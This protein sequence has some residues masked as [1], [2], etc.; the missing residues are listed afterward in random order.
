MKATTPRS[1]CLVFLLSANLFR[2][3]AWGQE[4]LVR[5]RIVVV[6]GDGTANTAGQRVS[7]DPVVEVQDENR[8]AVAGAAVTFFLPIQG[9]TGTFLN[10]SQT[11]TVNTNAQGRATASGI[12][13]NGSTGQMQI[14]V[15]ASFQGQ[16]ATATITENNQPGATSTGGL[17]RTGKLSIL[18]ALI[19]GATAGGILGTRGGS[20][21]T[22][23]APP[24]PPISITAGTPTVGG[25]R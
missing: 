6:E 13:L 11:L 16:T 12:R 24:P 1:I 18:F 5:L 19:A 14:R 4:P 20:S 17:S 9:P 21:S 2:P 10:G 15:T 3:L 23:P 8:M 25:P 7:H 22:A